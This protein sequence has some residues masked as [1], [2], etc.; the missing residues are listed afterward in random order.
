MKLLL[1]GLHISEVK[2]TLPTCRNIERD[3]ARGYEFW[4]SMRN[5]HQV[6]IRFK[7]IK[8]NIEKLYEK[9]TQMLEKVLQDNSII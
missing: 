1:T 9:S 5:M 3:L 8:P 6:M 4:K 7:V 2:E